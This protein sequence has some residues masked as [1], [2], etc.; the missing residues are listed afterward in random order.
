MGSTEMAVPAFPRKYSF[1]EMVQCSICLEALT[2]PRVLPCMH[3]FCLTCLKQCGQRRRAGEL[4]PCPLCRKQFKIPEGGLDELT[5]NFLMQ[6]LIDMQKAGPTN[7]TIKP[8]KDCLEE[9]GAF[10]LYCIDC[11]TNP[12]LKCT[13]DHETKQSFK[14]HKTLRLSDDNLMSELG[15]SL[16]QIFCKAHSKE[17]VR[18]FCFDCEQALCVRCQRKK[19]QSH[20][21]GDVGEIEDV[22]HGLIRRRIDCSA[23]FDV[24]HSSAEEQLVDKLRSF[25]EEV[26]VVRQKIQDQADTM[27]RCIDQHAME[28]L[29]KL[30]SMKERTV[31]EINNCRTALTKFKLSLDS[32]KHDVRDMENNNCASDLN[33]TLRDVDSKVKALDDERVK[34]LCR[35]RSACSSSVKFTTSRLE[36]ARS[37]DGRNIV[38]KLTGKNTTL[39][40]FQIRYFSNSILFNLDT[41]QTQFS[42]ISILFKL[43]ASHT[44]FFSNS[45]VS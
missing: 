12:C 34:M 39:Y 29:E 30:D 28:L 38:G 44:A 21:C 42:I 27:K 7:Q 3:T 31:L 18:V 33:S 8:C 4:F 35:S 32:F 41:F 43:G 5:K 24:Q 25:E 2:D 14:D 9:R 20:R 45:N 1:G 11:N 23:R 37:R 17:R 22:L 10:E 26:G 6:T 40:T 13:K 16:N 15:K 19:H 36:N